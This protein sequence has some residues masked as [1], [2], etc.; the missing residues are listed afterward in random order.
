MKSLVVTLAAALLLS[1]CQSRTDKDTIILYG[2]E[3]NSGTYMYFKEHVLNK[4]DFAPQVQTLPGTAAVINAVSKDPHSIGYGGIGYVKG[5]RAVPVK[6]DDNSPAVEPTLQSVV[7]GS[8]PISRYLYFY[9]VQEPQGAVG[10]FVAWVLGEEGQEVCQKVGYYPMPPERRGQM[11]FSGAPAEKKTI[12]VK[13]SDTMIILGQRW[14]EHYMA[15]VPGTVVQVTGGGSG[16]GIA[17]LI[18]GATDICQSSRPL[19]EKERGQIR[20]KFG[21]DPVEIPV[22]MDGLAVFVHE[23]NALKAITLA[24]LRAIYTGKVQSWRELGAASK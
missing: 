7:D 22:A 11:K 18:N 3:N 15:K 17:A 21:K 10:R 9:T 1:G 16:T 5:V 14:A 6:K 24:E 19:D 8:Y 2:R 4:T 23:S 13:G 20:A 12:T